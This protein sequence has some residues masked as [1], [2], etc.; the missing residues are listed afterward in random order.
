MRREI[1]P[2]PG[3]GEAAGEWLK[4]IKWRTEGGIAPKSVTKK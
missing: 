2:P 1:L 4:E 3:T